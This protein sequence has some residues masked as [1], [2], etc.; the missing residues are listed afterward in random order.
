MSAQQRVWLLLHVSRDD[1]ILLL[2]EVGLDLV[3]LITCGQEFLCFL[4][5]LVVGKFELKSSVLCYLQS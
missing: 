2:V 4:V 5:G 3:V 1:I